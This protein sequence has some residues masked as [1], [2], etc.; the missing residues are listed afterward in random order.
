[1]DAVQCIELFFGIINFAGWRKVNPLTAVSLNYIKIHYSSHDK[2]NKNA[3]N[4]SQYNPDA[5]VFH[6][7]DLEERLVSSA[8]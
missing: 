8:L 5:N 7:R 4:Q 6:G 1:M 2:L 3:Q